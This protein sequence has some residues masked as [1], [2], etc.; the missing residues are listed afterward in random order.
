ME[1]SEVSIGELLDYRS[2]LNRAAR[3]VI[4]PNNAQMGF[5]YSRIE[6]GMVRDLERMSGGSSLRGGNGRLS[7][8]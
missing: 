8:V 3:N 2:R 6:D 5:Y 7:I 1:A 4:D